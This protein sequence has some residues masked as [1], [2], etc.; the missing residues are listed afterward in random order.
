MLPPHEVRPAVLCGRG[1]V[2]RSLR[3]YAAGLLDTGPLDT[4]PLDT[5]PPELAGRFA[6]RLSDGSE[7]CLPLSF[8]E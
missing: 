3:R 2:C 4:R 5:G 6:L 7:R 1:A 8:R